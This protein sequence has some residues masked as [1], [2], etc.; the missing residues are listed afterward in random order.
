MMEKI[1][2]LVLFW[3]CTGS[4]GFRIALPC[5]NPGQRIFLFGC[6]SLL[7]AYCVAVCSLYLIGRG[8]VNPPAILLSCVILFIAVGFCIKKAYKLPHDTDISKA[9]DSFEFNARNIRRET[10]FQRAFIVVFL[11]FFLS[12]AY[13]TALEPL[14]GWDTLWYWAIVASNIMAESLNDNWLFLTAPHPSTMS[15][16]L[17]FPV[18][19]DDSG[20]RASSIFWILT[21]ASM[22]IMLYGQALSVTA[23]KICASTSAFV[24]ATMPL[25]ENL[26]SSAGYAELFVGASLLAFSTAFCFRLQNRFWVLL[27]CVLL[28]PILITKNTGPLF[29]LVIAGAAFLQVIVD[30]GYSYDLMVKYFAAT[31]VLA[32]LCM[33]F[34]QYVDFPIT[35][36]YRTLE[37]DVFR[38][39]MIFKN[40]FHAK[41]VNQSFSVLAILFFI[42]TS[43]FLSGASKNERQAI[44]PHIAFFLFSIGGL[45]ALLLFSQLS[46]Y[47]FN[48]GQPG[49]D[50]V[51]SRHNLPLA[52][53]VIMTVPY[54]YL[55]ALNGLHRYKD[56]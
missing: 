56:S 16:L 31:V 19:G 54:L 5:L 36:G 17:A 20:H 7:G 35:M 1:S 38:W 51:I 25:A 45:L 30:R 50:T 13:R 27:S 2:L 47:G 42:A 28:F 24:F 18:M 3:V 22:L 6:F 10:L 29:F 33:C 48:R 34:L 46:T 23:S 12:Y 4:V 41:I 39:P 14:W 8:V 26:A 9:H 43:I 32:F 49:A 52:T 53:L 11:V 15:A 40:E 21:Y 44:Y 37:F 55:M